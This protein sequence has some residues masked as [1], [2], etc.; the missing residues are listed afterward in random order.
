MPPI[1]S[2]KSLPDAANAHIYTCR[3]ALW[4]LNL[5][6]VVLLMQVL[7]VDPH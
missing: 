4:A 5:Q 7:A 3:I 2:A 6:F 1:M